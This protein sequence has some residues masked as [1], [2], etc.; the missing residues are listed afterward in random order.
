M[1]NCKHCYFYRTSERDCYN[2]QSCSSFTPITDYLIDEEIRMEHER[3][4]NE[5]YDAWQ[6][7]IRDYN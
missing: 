1:N 3:L 7:Y 5:Y 4:K 2:I 6:D